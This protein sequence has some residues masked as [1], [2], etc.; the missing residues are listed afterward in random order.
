MRGKKMYT[1]SENIMPLKMFGE[2]D[3][4][5]KYLIIVIFLYYPGRVDIFFSI[6]LEIDSS[7]S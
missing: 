1:L 3:K 6:Y 5:K 4:L 2:K 7:A